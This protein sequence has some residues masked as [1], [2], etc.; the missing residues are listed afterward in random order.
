MSDTLNFA[1]EELE[2]AGYFDKDSDY[3]G[4]IGNAVME[5]LK[6]FAGQHHS[7]FSAILVARI[8]NQLVSHIPLTPLTGEDDEWIEVDDNFLMNKRCPRIIKENGK[9][10]DTERI[11][12]EDKNTMTFTHSEHS[13]V[14]I[15]FPY[16]PRRETIKEGT[17]E[18]EKFNG[19]FGGSKQ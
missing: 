1:R 2:R 4:E 16:F 6:T 17:P 18:A 13:R 3:E 14:E 19:V 11:V 7:G 5:L 9:A 15:S 10:Y 8:F 12:F